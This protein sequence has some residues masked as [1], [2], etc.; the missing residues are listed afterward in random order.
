MFLEKLALIL[1]VLVALYCTS[2][3]SRLRSTAF[4]D[5]SNLCQGSFDQPTLCYAE[6]NK[7]LVLEC[8][9][10]AYY[11]YF[12]PNGQNRSLGNLYNPN[13]PNN[14][15]ISSDDEETVA[16]LEIKNVNAQDYGLSAFAARQRPSKT[17]KQCLFNVF[18]YGKINS[19]FRLKSKDNPYFLF[20]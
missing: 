13:D 18:V 3:E 10:E 19:L 16:R 8:S 20:L 5:C 9:F 7:C 11:W 15:L 17:T 14:Y 2:I 6:A 12:Q 4:G 1:F